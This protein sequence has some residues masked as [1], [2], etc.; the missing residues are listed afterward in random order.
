M[1]LPKIIRT[2]RKTIALIV[3][4][5]GSLVVRAPLRASNRQIAEIVEQKAEWIRT[6]LAQAIARPQP[7]THKFASGEQFW[8]LGRAYPLTISQGAQD[9]LE[10]SAGQFKLFLRLVSPLRAAH[11]KEK[12]A[13]ALFIAWYRRQACQVL[14]ERVSFLAR[15]TRFSYCQV[16]IT[17]A[18][19][20]WGS[21]SGRG[22]LSFSWRLVM[23][24]LAVID[25]VV[26]HELVHTVI[27]GH[28]QDFWGRVEALTP[29]YKRYIRW[30]KENGAKLEV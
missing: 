11:G 12:M 26:V 24:P 18:H 6:R 5:D 10:L 2:R 15:L 16:K 4:A 3:Q 23:A 28:G 29:E 27:K 1:P 17:S 22:T 20:R 21:C 19:T 13:Q 9:R 30:L 7:E 8:Y 25:Y 14:E